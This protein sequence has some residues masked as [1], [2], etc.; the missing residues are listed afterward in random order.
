MEHQKMGI[1]DS[2][3]KGQIELTA[4]SEKQTLTDA[5]DIARVGGNLNQGIGK[6]PDTSNLHELKIAGLTTLSGS[7]TGGVIGSGIGLGLEAGVQT[8]KIP[9]AFGFAAMGGSQMA[10]GL[11]RTESEYMSSAAKYGVR[12]LIGGA[13]LGAAA[14]G[15]YELK[16]NYYDK[17]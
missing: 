17:T 12:G 6:L 10:A 15:I 4:P 3:G 1:F 2:L 9:L 13:L 11:I 14:F 7:L 16:K 8:L 5:T